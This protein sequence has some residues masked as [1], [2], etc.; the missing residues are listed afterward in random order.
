MNFNA[1][2]GHDRQIQILQKAIAS[3]QLAHGYLFDGRGGI[4]K[5]QVAFAL[6]KTM[7]C[8][9]GIDPCNLCPSCVQFDSGNHPDYLYIEPDGLSIKDKQ[10]ES[11]Q[12]FIQLKPFES[13]TKVVIVEQ[14]D[15]MTVRAQNRILKVIEEP[16]GHALILFITENKET[17]LPTV[18]SRLQLLSFNRISPEKMEPWLLTQGYEEETSHLA[19]LYADGSLGMAVKLLS[20]PDFHQM[21]EAAL[22]C[23]AALHEGDTLKAFERMEPYLADKVSTISFM[24]LMIIWYRDTL[25][26]KSHPDSPLRFTQEVTETFSSLSRHIEIRRVPLYIEIAESAKKAIGA[27]A[28]HPLVAEAMLLKLTG[29]QL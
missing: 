15:L 26:L 8:G 14:A 21:R 4:G 2:I 6:A 3:Q 1:I 20:T 19:A 23:L 18:L 11:F 13:D 17:L 28:N 16:P 5:K 7:L 9:K 12:E 22:G 10:L 24:D 29:G 27:N 25:L